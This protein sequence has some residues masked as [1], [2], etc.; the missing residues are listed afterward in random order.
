[1]E[2]QLLSFQYT[3]KMSGF[4]L[5]GFHLISSA[6]TNYMV[7]WSFTCSEKKPYIDNAVQLTVITLLSINVY[8]MVVLYQDI[9]N[10][11]G[12]KQTREGG[13]PYGN[14]TYLFFQTI[15]TMAHIVAIAYWALRLKDITLVV[16][17][18]E[19]HTVDWRSSYTHGLN[20]I[21]MYI[22]LAF[23]TQI[24][25]KKRLWKCIHFFEIT[26]SYV[27]LQYVYFAITGKLVYPFLGALP[28]WIVGAFYTTLFLFLLCVDIWGTFL[29]SSFHGR[30]AFE[31]LDEKIHNFAKAQKAHKV[32]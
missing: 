3:S 17:E 20:L 31:V 12:R 30:K 8:Y 27:I 25:P 24:L 13:L 21:P 1:L 14:K 2:E 29:I 9:L 6:I 23:F 19:L 26:A 22:E 15:F 10:I 7:Y 16:P 4:G 11:L 18:D 28:L 5:F 32:F